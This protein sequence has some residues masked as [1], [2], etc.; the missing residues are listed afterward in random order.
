ML[1]QSVM[2]VVFVLGEQITLGKFLLNGSEVTLNGYSKYKSAIE[3]S[4]FGNE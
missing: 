3:T 2:I 4:S 1:A